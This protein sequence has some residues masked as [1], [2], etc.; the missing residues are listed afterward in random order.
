MN[1]KSLSLRN[2]ECPKWQ[3]DILRPPPHMSNATYPDASKFSVR[4][5]LRGQAEVVICDY[6]FAEYDKGVLLDV[7]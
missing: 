7:P 2:R 4:K 6:G 1:A 5:K 3:L